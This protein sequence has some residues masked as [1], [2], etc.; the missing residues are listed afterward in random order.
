M[1]ITM[2]R[3]LGHDQLLIILL[4]LPAP[5]ALPLG[6]QCHLTMNLIIM[7]LQLP[8][9]MALPL[10]HQCHLFMNL[11]HMQCNTLNKQAPTRTISIPHPH[12][13]NSHCLH[14]HIIWKIGIGNIHRKMSTIGKQSSQQYL[15][16]LQQSYLLLSFWGTWRS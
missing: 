7:I 5:L 16:D 6:R 8:D 1:E 2:G 13:M 10:S 12:L 9:P 4:Q 15:L 14:H 3:M 11:L